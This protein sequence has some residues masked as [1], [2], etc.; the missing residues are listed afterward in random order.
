[1]TELPLTG[2]LKKET[3]CI[4]AKKTSWTCSSSQHVK[5]NLWKSLIHFGIQLLNLGNIIGK[6][7]NNS[8]PHDLSG[9]YTVN[10]QQG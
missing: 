6:N 2:K 7:A 3:S 5:F 4:I 8:G 10:K 9:Y 1:M